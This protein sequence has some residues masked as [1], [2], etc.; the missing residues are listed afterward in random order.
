[1]FSEKYLAGF[2]DADGH[3]SV[4]A[5][6]GAKPDLEVSCCQRSIYS[7]PLFYARDLF[8]GSIREK[9]DGK[10]LEW[11]ARGGIARKAYERLKKYLVLKKDHASLFLELVDSSFV[12]HSDEDVRMIRN[13]VKEI[14]KY[15]ATSQPNFP[16]RKWMAGY[17]DGDG[18]F[19]VKLCK[20]TGYAYP[21]LCILSAP[22]YVVGI[23]LLQKAFNGNICGI[24]QN[25]QWTLSLSQPSKVKQLL[26]YCGKYLFIK[27]PQGQFILGCAANGNFRD[28]ANIRETIKALNSRQHRLSD[29]DVNK[30][31]NAINFNIEKKPLGRPSG[32]VETNKR[33][34][35]SKL[36]NM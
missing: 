36:R 27:K 20:K 5:R 11:Q 15:G 17:I 21:L 22:N 10:Y 18:S 16:S 33:K 7:E 13:R 28:G 30:L 32:I 9:Y 19:N 4:R 1:M 2:L 8:G 12:L 26:E 14:R 23:T 31:V 6:K 3:F 24:G 35:Q 34:R 29:S 25:A